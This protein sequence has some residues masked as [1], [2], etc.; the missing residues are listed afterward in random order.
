[1]FIIRY[2]TRRVIGHIGASIETYW[3]TIC[4]A[5]VAGTRGG[6]QRKLI[7]KLSCQVNLEPRRLRKTRVKRQFGYCKV[8]YR[9]FDKNAHRPFVA[10]ALSNIVMARKTLV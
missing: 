10:H 7:S 4:E 3:S 9:W 5:I 6:S 2:Q 1:M 8:R